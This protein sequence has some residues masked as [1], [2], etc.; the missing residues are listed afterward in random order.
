M[1][2]GITGKADLHIHTAHSDGMAEAR[3]LLD[4]VESETDLDV[5][6]IVDHDD[7]RGALSAREEWARGR[8][9]FELV[10]GIE[11]TTIQGHLLALF[12]EEP[13]PSLRPLE[14]TL[15]AIHRQGG[16]SIVP[17]PLNWLTRSLTS[18][19]IQRILRNGKGGVFFDGIEMANP[20]PGS[21]MGA[22]K[23]LELN[24]N[25]FHLAE[26]GGSD[27][28][29]L[30]SVGSCFTEFPGKSAHDLREG[31]LASATRGVNGR[32][33]GLREIGIGQVM[34]QTWRGFTVT[35]RKMGWGPTARSFMKRITGI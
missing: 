11:V 6:G 16:L 27:A 3:Q 34:R 13:V 12:I 7:V 21:R 1:I 24:S 5:I 8:Y 30:M 2:A 31:I 22:R 26:V 15:E 28:H 32:C 20:A 19:T 29:F 17:H 35:P 10:T 33:P 4:Y 18:R 14:E 23:A 9:G 25:S